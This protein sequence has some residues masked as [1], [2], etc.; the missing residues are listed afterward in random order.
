MILKSEKCCQLIKLQYRINIGYPLEKYKKNTRLNECLLYFTPTRIYNNFLVY[1][2]YT[3]LYCI[4]D[5]FCFG[6]KNDPKDEY[7]TF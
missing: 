5:D 4:F 1:S 2:L 6:S 3:L 7:T